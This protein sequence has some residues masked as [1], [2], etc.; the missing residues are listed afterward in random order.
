MKFEFKDSIPLFVLVVSLS[1]ALFNPIIR[2]SEVLRVGWAIIHTIIAVSYVT[3]LIIL[4][5]IRFP[6]SAR[7]E[8]EVKE[9][10]T[11]AHKILK[12]VSKSPPGSGVWNR[13]KGYTEALELVLEKIQKE[14]E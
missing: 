3:G 13:M 5:A 11:K 12:D 1:M 8:K 4:K 2:S 14:H 6:R 7:I 10:L 9:Q